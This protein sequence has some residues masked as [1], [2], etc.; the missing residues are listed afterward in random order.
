MQEIERKFLV[1]ALPGDLA[2]FPHVEIHQGYLAYEPGDRQV[3]IRR[4]GDE[5][6][7]TVKVRL[8]GC[9]EEVTIALTPDDFAC[10][11]PITKGRR[12]HKTRYRIPHGEL[13]IEIDV[14]HGKWNGLLVAEVEFE[15]E[16]LCR[17]FIAP[18]WLGEDVTLNPAYK[19]TALAV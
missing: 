6:W 14:Y 5:C 3:R 12:L 18:D 1:K 16:Q 11:W 8:G 4:I 2:A 7:L 17:D 9:R 19:N 10:L 15:D 13:M